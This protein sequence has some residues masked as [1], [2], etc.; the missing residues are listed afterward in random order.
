ERP[1][2]IDRTLTT[3][4][5]GGH[6][7]NVR[8]VVLGE[9]TNCDPGIDGICAQ[10]VVRSVFEPHAIPV[11]EGFPIGHGILNTPLHFGANVEVQANSDKASV[12][13]G[14]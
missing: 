14:F 8:A 6:F 4:S 13:L 10:E 3:L 5:V 12:R 1:Y 9:F 2:R 11:V 7:D